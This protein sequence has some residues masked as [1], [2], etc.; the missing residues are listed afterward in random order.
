MRAICPTRSWTSRAA[1]ACWA[2]RFAMSSSVLGEPT[3]AETFRAFWTASMRVFLSSA[4]AMARWW[5]TS[6]SRRSVVD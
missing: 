5:P 2:Y 4:P 1:S 6:F 3:G